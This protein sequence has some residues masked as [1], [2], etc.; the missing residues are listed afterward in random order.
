M[1]TELNANPRDLDLY[2]RRQPTLS[3]HLERVRTW[4]VWGNWWL[5][6]WPGRG[7]DGRSFGGVADYCLH[8]PRMPGEAH[9]PESAECTPIGPNDLLIA[10]QALALGLTVVTANIDEFSRVPG[11][12]VENWLSE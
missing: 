5:S 4:S 8:D 7:S 11:L 1:A 10:A 9:H 2:A 3:A 12:G 6:C